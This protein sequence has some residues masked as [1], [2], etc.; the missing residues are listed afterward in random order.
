NIEKILLLVEKLGSKNAQEATLS[1]TIMSER[2]N[3]IA[4]AALKA[5]KVCADGA[6][7]MQPGHLSTGPKETQKDAIITHR[8]QVTDQGQLKDIMYHAKA[9]KALDEKKVKLDLA[10]H[11]AAKPV[12]TSTV[13]AGRLSDGRQMYGQAPKGSLERDF[14]SWLEQLGTMAAHDN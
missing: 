9:A 6:K 1:K 8:Q 13:R 3:V 5:M 2:G 14:Q 7:E 10:G 12:V 11:S 4:E